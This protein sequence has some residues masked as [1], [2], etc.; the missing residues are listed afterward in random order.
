MKRFILLLLILTAYYFTA[1][2]SKKQEST[3]TLSQESTAVKNEVENTTEYKYI[4]F[5]GNSLTAGYG[6]EEDESFPS[7]IQNKID[8]EGLGYKVINAG[9]SGE[10]TANGNERIDWIL[11]QDIDVFVLEL[12]ANDML[13]GL[14]VE[15]TFI[16][17]KS[18]VDKVKLK[19][20]EIH[21]IIAGMKAAPNMGQEYVSKFDNIFTRLANEYQT[22]LIP[23]LLEGVASVD[24]LNLDD[25]KHPNAEGQT[26]VANTVWKVLK[27]YLD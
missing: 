19:D 5:F 26:I 20:P 6:L 8:E 15:Q 11:K 21:I 25:G 18:I 9:L 2:D 10:T 7:L 24:S 12:G 22:G 1:C 3:T 17:L 4:L 14:S 27:P 13:R 23:F 16:N